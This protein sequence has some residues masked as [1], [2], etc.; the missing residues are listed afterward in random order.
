MLRSTPCRRGVA[1]L[2]PVGLLALLFLVWVTVP[3]GLQGARGVPV[4]PVSVT[5]TPID[6]EFSATPR[7][8]S[9]PMGV[10]F[11]DASTGGPSSWSWDFGDGSSSPE[12]NPFHVYQRP[13]LYTVILGV[14]NLS[15][16]DMEVKVGH[17]LVG[18]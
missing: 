16:H 4:P 5:F 13:G 11:T 6:A 7:F 1:A 2:E 12:Q 17:V 10:Q 18:P 9:S 8:G 3:N 14:A 15:S